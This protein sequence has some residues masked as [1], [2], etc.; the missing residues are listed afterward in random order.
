M[1]SDVDRNY[2]E[3]GLHSIP[4]VYAMKGY[5]LSNQVMRNMMEFVLTECAKRGLYTPVCCFDG[6]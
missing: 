5:S 4:I 2:R 6:Q 3:E 1:I